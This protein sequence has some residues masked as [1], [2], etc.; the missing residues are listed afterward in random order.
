MINKK[1]LLTIGLISLALTAC[2]SNTQQK[3]ATS[4]DST[5]ETSSD[6]AMSS[7]TE[8]TDLDSEL[9]SINITDPTEELLNSE[10]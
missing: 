6:P 10:K 7:S 2:T 5:Q 1:T 9:N 4:S 3:N 8:P